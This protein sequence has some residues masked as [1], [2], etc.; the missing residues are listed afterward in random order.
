MLLRAG[1][2]T[3][4]HRHA[5][6]E[7]VLQLVSGRVEQRV[8]AAAAC[9]MEPGDAVFIPAG[10][11]HASRALGAEDARIR[12]SYSAAQREYEELPAPAPD[13][14]GK[15]ERVASAEE[16]RRIVGEPHPLTAHKLLPRLD[17]AARDFIARSPLALLA[18]LD[19]AGRP[20][21]SPRGDEPGFVRVLDEATLLIPER[22]GNRLAFGLGN[23]LERP[24][25][26]LIFLVPGTEE[27]LRVHGSAEILATP[28]LLASLA[29][30]GRPAVLALRV[31][32]ARCFF[33]CARALKRSR[34]W[35][36]ASWPPPLE[37]SLGAVIAEALQA[38]EGLAREIDARIREGYQGEL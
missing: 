23:L 18:T 28:A 9:V 17:P 32:V 2:Q 21:V 8:G 10:V 31:R 7:E 34:L 16:L 37:L 26:A 38:G 36:P 33:Q 22:P 14:P 20:D 27:T 11:P 30:R 24:E 4:L 19:A 35:D 1:Q 6:C 15:Q 12:L 25:V 13:A 3:A 29:A 5:N